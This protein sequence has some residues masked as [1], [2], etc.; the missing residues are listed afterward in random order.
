MA[1]E[2]W[3]RSDSA[4]LGR[5][6]PVDCLYDVGRRKSRRHVESIRH[7]IDASS[8]VD[9][10]AFPIEAQFVIFAENDKYPSIARSRRPRLPPHQ[11]GY[12]GCQ[13][14][15]LSEFLFPVSLPG[16]G[17]G[18][19]TVL[20]FLTFRFAILL[21]AGVHHLWPLYQH[22]NRDFHFESC[23]RLAPRPDGLQTPGTV[24]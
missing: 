14:M 13:Q 2:S 12:L 15:Q 16:R 11:Y 22:V 4:F 24:R 9:L 10:V 5:R 7:T 3:K 17:H 6:L 23:F 19:G 20:L 18:A 1:F 8:N 21:S